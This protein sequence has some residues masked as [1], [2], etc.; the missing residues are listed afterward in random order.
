MLGPE[1]KEVAGCSKKLHNK[2]FLN[3]YPSQAI[4][5]LSNLEECDGWDM[6]NP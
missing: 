5:G 4:L 1:R 6:W 3:L 2:G